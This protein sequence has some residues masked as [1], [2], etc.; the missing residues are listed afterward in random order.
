M[1]HD[2]D[3]LGCGFGHK[4]V[5][6]VQHVFLGGTV[7]LQHKKNSN[8]ISK[9][10]ET[11]RTYK[12]EMQCNYKTFKICVHPVR[13]SR[14]LSRILMV[15]HQNLNPGASQKERYKR[16]TKK[17]WWPKVI[18]IKSHTSVDQ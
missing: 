7:F 12:L 17:W 3:I 13:E 4:V 9:T 6:H 15:Q 2:E 16:E 18:S 10:K 5:P 1:G 14:V 11:D 8:V